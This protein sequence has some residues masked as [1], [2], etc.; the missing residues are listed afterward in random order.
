MLALLPNWLKSPAIGLVA[1]FALVVG[2]Y[3]V[4]KS[5]GRT[6]G[7]LKVAEIEIKAAKKALE[8][9][10]NLEKN[11]ATF[12]NLTPRHRCLALMRDSKLPDTACDG[13]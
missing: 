3:A 13:D 8:R 6:E 11:N 5:E 4:G 9:V 10:T 12:R 7:D 1:A 2:S